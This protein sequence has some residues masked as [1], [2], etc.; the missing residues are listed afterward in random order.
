MGWVERVGVWWGY[1]LL[2][3]GD[4]WFGG[5][6]IMWIGLLLVWREWC[7]GEEMLKGGGLL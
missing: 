7:D 1:K 6:V 2:G 3:G 5:I 4:I